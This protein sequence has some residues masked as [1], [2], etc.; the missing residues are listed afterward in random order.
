MA[1]RWLLSS[2]S[3]RLGKSLETISEVKSLS[4]V[5]LFATIWTEYSLPSSSVHGIFQARILEWVSIFFFRRPS[6]SGIEP[7]SP[8][9]QADAL[10]SEPPRKS[11]PEVL[12]GNHYRLA[13]SLE[14]I[15]VRS[16]FIFLC[17][18]ISKRSSKLLKP[19]V[20]SNRII[21]TIGI[22]N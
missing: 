2:S 19:R 7:R 16:C 17:L 21:S 4:H 13:R 22:K 1:L 20:I 18:A 10:P 6:Q 5:Q 12:T 14:T 15:T 9:L 3:E 11:L 8:T